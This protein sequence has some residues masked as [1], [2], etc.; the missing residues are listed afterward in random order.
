MPDT[1]GEVEKGFLPIFQKQAFCLVEG[2]KV[3][4]VKK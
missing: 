4:Q 1:L 2:E 3:C